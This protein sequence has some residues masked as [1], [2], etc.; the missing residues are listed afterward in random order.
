MTF[1]ASQTGNQ[2]D[3]ETPKDKNWHLKKTNKLRSLSYFLPVWRDRDTVSQ[4]KWIQMT[5]SVP[6]VRIS[7]RSEWRDLQKKPKWSQCIWDPALLLFSF[8]AFQMSPCER[9]LCLSLVATRYLGDKQTRSRRR[10]SCTC[11]YI[12]ETYT[13][14]GG[15][16]RRR[17]KRPLLAAVTGCGS[18]FSFVSPCCSTSAITSGFTSCAV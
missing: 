5:S 3:P 9:R 18:S 14:S 15:S 13:D 1:L 2:P 8:E 17:G 12:T 10:Q 11:I 16:A 4:T 7:N 6:G